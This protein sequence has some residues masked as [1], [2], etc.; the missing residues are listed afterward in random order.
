M[1]HDP[2]IAV[3]EVD[4]FSQIL[5]HHLRF[6]ELSG[7]KRTCEVIMGKLGY[8][9]EQAGKTRVNIVR[10]RRFQLFCKSCNF[11]LPPNIHGKM[12]CPTDGTRLS[13]WNL[14][15]ENPLPDR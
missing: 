12:V 11:K 8:M 14:D 13:Y 5:D 9:A 6:I 10:G 7:D 4:A 1:T 2:L 3:A 15:R